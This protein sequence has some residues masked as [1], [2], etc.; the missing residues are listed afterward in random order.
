[1]PLKN[2]SHTPGQRRF[3][4]EDDKTRQQQARAKLR[5]RGAV[6]LRTN[7]LEEPEQRVRSNRPLIDTVSEEWNE[8]PF[9]SLRDPYEGE[10]E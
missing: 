6:R 7:G 4:Q 3:L 1:M 10:D 9:E 5:D 8:D 2:S